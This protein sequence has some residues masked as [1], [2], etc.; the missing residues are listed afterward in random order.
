M[1]NQILW[2]SAGKTYFLLQTALSSH[3]L[4]L[5]GGSLIS[6]LLCFQHGNKHNNLSTS[7]TP[8]ASWT[9]VSCPVRSQWC[10]ILRSE[11]TRRS[12]MPMLYKYL[13]HSFLT[14][15]LK[16]VE[17]MGLELSSFEKLSKIGY[18]TGKSSEAIWIHKQSILLIQIFSMNKLI[19]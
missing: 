11:L 15:T 16:I 2:K 19:W 17:I 7:T 13:R 10:A 8:S 6:L 4:L 3:F 1:M 9:A 14:H 18:K 5:M 12:L